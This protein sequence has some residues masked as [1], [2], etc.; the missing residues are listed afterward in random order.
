MDVI[1]AACHLQTLAA[2]RRVEV[3]D[4]YVALDWECKGAHAAT[5]GAFEA[6]RDRALEY[7]ILSCATQTADPR[8]RALGHMMAHNR[9]WWPCGPALPAKAVERALEEPHQHL[10]IFDNGRFVLT[11]SP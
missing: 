3:A 10:A 5:K 6:L 9:R 8:T 11:S 7:T 4:V 1:V 2:P